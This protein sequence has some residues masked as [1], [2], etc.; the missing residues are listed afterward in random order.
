M[1]KSDRTSKKIK[2]QRRPHDTQ[3]ASERLERDRVSDKVIAGVCSSCAC[4]KK[5]AGSWTRR[6][7]APVHPVHEGGVEDK[8]RAALNDSFRACRREQR[9][10][11]RNT[12]QA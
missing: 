3:K 9:G 8:A 7:L 1:G 6:L 2:V 10:R 11:G 12:I 5:G 4:K